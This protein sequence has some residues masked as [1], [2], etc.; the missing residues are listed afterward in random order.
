MR[1]LV[2]GTLGKP[3][4]HHFADP[5]GACSVNVFEAGGKHGWHF[6][7]SEFT[8]TLMLQ[9]PGSGGDFEYVPGLRGRPDELAV[10]EEVL[11]G[12]RS[13]VERLPFVEGTLLIFGGSRTLHRVTE[14]SGEQ[15]RLVPVL[16]FSEQP[17]AVNSEAVRKLF[18]GRSH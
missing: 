5:L 8:I 10:V 17:A 12:S 7:E 2:R 14:I 6:D 11:K 1:E 16:C 18:W 13:G 9:R 15:L 4:L 3:A